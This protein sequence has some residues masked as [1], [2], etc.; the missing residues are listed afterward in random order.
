MWLFVLELDRSSCHL[1]CH[2]YLLPRPKQQARTSL[3]RPKHVCASWFFFCWSKHIFHWTICLQRLH[4]WPHETN[5]HA[6]QHC[7]KKPA[8]KITILLLEKLVP[9]QTVVHRPP[10]PPWQCREKRRTTAI[11]RSGR[12]PSHTRMLFEPMNRIVTSDE[13]ETLWHVGRGSSPWSP[14][15]SAVIFIWCNRKRETPPPAVF[16]A[17][18]CK[19]PNITIVAGAAATRESAGHRPDTNLTGFGDRR[20]DRATCPPTPLAR[21]T[22]RRRRSR[23]KLFQYG[24][25]SSIITTPQES[26]RPPNY[27]LEAGVP[28]PSCRR[29]GG[30]RRQGPAAAA[31]GGNVAR[32]TSRRS[33]FASGAV[34]LRPNFLTRTF[35]NPF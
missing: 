19:T 14:D 15:P 31:R 7:T 3:S 6:R 2:K 18:N 29:S 26:T 11:P 13:S 9:R 23:D 17:D 20:E 27:R 16:H 34:L 12:A 8:S 5:M 24:A 35:F 21:A 10:P 33:S 22:T 25:V 4:I 32:I 28:T 30:W 1:W